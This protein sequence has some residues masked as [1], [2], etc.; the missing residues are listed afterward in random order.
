MRLKIFNFYMRQKIEIKQFIP[1][2]FFL[3]YPLF[4]NLFTPIFSF[5]TKS[6]YITLR[7]DGTGTKYIFYAHYGSNCNPLFNYPNEVYINNVKQD[8]VLNYYNF[9]E[10]K[11]EVILLWNSTITSCNCLFLGCEDIKEIVFSNFDT[12]KIVYMSY[13]FSECSSLTSLD[14]T[15]FDTTKLY[16]IQHMFSFCTS[17]KSLDLSNFKTPNLEIMVS[18]FGY[19]SSL[20]SLDISNFDTS[21]VTNMV[22]IF[23]ACYKL[24]SLNLSN[25]N[26]AKVQTMRGI[27]NSCYSLKTLNLMSFDTTNVIDMEDIFSDCSSLVSINISSFRTSNTNKMNRFFAGCSSLTSLD[28]TSFDTS[29]VKNTAEMFSECSN[30]K[31]LNLSQFSLAQVT[32]MDKM[33]YNCKNLEYVNL[34]NVKIKSSSTSMNNIFFNSILNIV[35]CTN[36]AILINKIKENKCAI[37]DCSEFWKEKRKKIIIS[38]NTCVDSCS[39]VLNTFE[40][41]SKCY[42][43]CS[44]GKYNYINFDSNNNYRISCIN[45][46]VGYYLDKEDSL[47]KSCY[48][49]CKSCYKKGDE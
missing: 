13:M 47:Y 31:I 26:T 10:P 5:S 3:T 41:D 39:L 6:T 34:H 44:V 24:T 12:S 18:M 37:I 38:N 22:T 21:K 20:T 36:D 28:L 17:L 33:F 49:S 25:F 11:N 46:L 32:N 42:Q 16:N 23:C 1:I 45:T 40:Y 27:F 15:S 35:V 2:K 7:I 30:L 14:L 4:L 29:N 8:K 9:I 19:C 48:P 43:N